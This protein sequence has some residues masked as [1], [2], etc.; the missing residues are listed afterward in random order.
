VFET[1]GYSQFINAIF[2]LLILLT[3]SP[4]NK[5]MDD[6]NTALW[7]IP[8]FEFGDFVPILL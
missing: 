7:T 4:Q 3:L 6:S 5:I 8:N 2:G 1:I